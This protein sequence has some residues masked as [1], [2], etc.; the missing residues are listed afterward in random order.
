M[1]RLTLLA[2]IVA[3]G[4]PV[5]ARAYSLKDD[6]TGNGYADFFSK[7]SF[8][9][10]ADPTDGFVDY[11]DENTAWSE[12]LIGNGGNIYIGVDNKN[13]ADDSGRKSIRLTSTAS[14]D[15]NTLFVA[16]ISHMP[17][18]ICGTWPAFWTTS[19]T[20][21]WP[22]EGEI[23]MIEQANNA[24]TNQMSLHV[25]KDQGRC[26]ISTGAN[27]TAKE[28][29]WGDCTEEDTGGCDATDSRTTSFGAGF[30]NDNGGVYAM[31]WTAVYVRIWFFPRSAIPSG[32]SGPLGSSP[33]PTSWGTPTTSFHSQ[34]ETGCDMS[35]HIKNQRIII[36]TTF[37]GT[38][39][40]DDWEG[41]GCAASTGSSTCED[42]V[43]NN[44]SA[45]TDAFW[46]FD[47]IQVFT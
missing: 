8:W 16:N 47:S 35:E 25:S 2:P 44:P 11:V 10:T 41:S 12:G 37:C 40:G 13:V 24:D 26:T 15:P 34:H 9:T 17:G 30:N 28:G 33:D 29:R 14:Y 7:F 39:A 38:W 18:G 32:D 45:F 1:P 3:L 23:D 4:L 19:S 36:D 22:Q 20:S 5:V 42:Y 43:K 6:Y 21:N 27:M 31:E 46:T